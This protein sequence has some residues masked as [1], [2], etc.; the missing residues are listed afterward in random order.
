VFSPFIQRVAENFEAEPAFRAAGKAI[1]DGA[2][3]SV[4]SFAVDILG[5]VDESSKYWKTP[6]RTVPDVRPVFCAR[7]SPANQLTHI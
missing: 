6:W 2:I 5:Y 1:A 4:N 7:K 3:G